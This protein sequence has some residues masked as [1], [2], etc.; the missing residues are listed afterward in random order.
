MEEDYADE[1]LEEESN[2][3]GGTGEGSIESIPIESMRVRF[4]P[5]KFQATKLDSIEE[6]EKEQLPLQCTERCNLPVMPAAM[7]VA[8]EHCNVELVFHR[9]DFPVHFV[10]GERSA[11]CRGGDADAARE[12][13]SVLGGCDAG[14]SRHLHASHRQVLEEKERCQ[15]A[16]TFMKCIRNTLT[17]VLIA[18]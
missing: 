16:T 3:N 14:S 2:F 13:C 17:E 15:L 12:F 18:Q 8:A 4:E 5:A 11:G 10:A 6:E 1:E 9:P 7:V